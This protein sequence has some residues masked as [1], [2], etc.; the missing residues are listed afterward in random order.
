MTTN[1]QKAWEL[2][3]PNLGSAEYIK[4]SRLVPYKDTGLS[5]CERCEEPNCIIALLYILEG[6]KIEDM[7]AWNDRSIYPMYD[8]IPILHKYDCDFLTDLQ[9]A[10]DSGDVEWVDSLIA[11]MS[12]SVR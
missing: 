7:R 4:T 5:V 12:D 9:D 10:F 6:G 8:K 11:S 3:R 1:L 2:S